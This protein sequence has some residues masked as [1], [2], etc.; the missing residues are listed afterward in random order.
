MNRDRLLQRLDAHWDM[1]VIGGGAT[2]LGCAVDAAS[3]GY[4]TLLL[5]QCDFAKATSSRSTKLIHGGVR[6]LK[7]GNLSLVMEALHER[8]LLIQ[9]A[10]HLVKSLSFV[11]P[12]Y[13][14]FK[15]PFYGIGLKLYD[16]M[17]G[18]LSL[19]PSRYMNRQETL[20]HIPTV[21]SQ[22]LQG[23]VIYHDAQFDD[24]RL[25]VHLA[26]TLEE[27]GGTAINYMRVTRLHRSGD[28]IKGL[29]ALDRETEQEYRLQAKVIINACGIFTD[30][31]RQMDDPSANRIMTH[32]QGIHLVLDGS[33]LSE[34][35]AIMMP[36]T[37]DG[38]VFFAIPWH[39]RVIV[40]TTETPVS[41]VSE[42]PLPSDEE[43]DFLLQHVT[44][45]IK[46][47]SRADVLS[48]FAGL[49]PL[50]KS[51]DTLETAKISREHAVIT[52]RSGLVSITGGKWTTYRKMAED[53]VN[54]AA[55]AAGLKAKPC[56]TAHLKLHGACE[57]AE[58][59]PPWD[60][61][62]SDA[63]ELQSLAKQE[64]LE[65]KLHEKL[66]YLA[67]EVIWAVRKEWART[68]EDVL[69]RRTRALLLDAEASISI[70]ADIAKLMAKELGRD[71]AWQKTQVIRYLELAQRYLPQSR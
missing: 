13:D 10:P 45:Y 22:G 7:Q 70:A 12:V 61:Y 60:V 8:G 55:I 9:N 36:N 4:K 34:K 35:S 29:T 33:F 17:A 67:C 37:S 18:K 16:K 39:Q 52:S 32:S 54:Q 50:F 6:Y 11:I 43:I 51:Q 14:R 57:N 2:G 65:K 25:A 23:G 5:E 31:V 64:G 68:V 48:V 26:R 59:N 28:K 46:P 40:G 49:R 44:R 41:H 38:R 20:K 27:L 53:T 63:K 30:A 66:P 69:S 56:I 42:E 58:A 3:R 47:A 15:G 62:G 19:G 24:A 71:E 1:I 21:A